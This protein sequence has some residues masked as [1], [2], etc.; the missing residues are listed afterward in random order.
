MAFGPLALEQIV[1]EWNMQKELLEMGDFADL[2]PQ[3]SEGIFNDWWNV[4]WIPFASNGGGDYYCVDMAPTDVGTTGQII[5]HF[6]ESGE[7]QVLAPSLGEYLNDLANL[8][9]GNALEYDADDGIRKKK[10]DG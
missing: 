9:E 2:E 6:H 1:Q 7:H 3:S 4:G 8:L 10:S 5:S